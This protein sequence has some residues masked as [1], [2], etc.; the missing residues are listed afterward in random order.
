[1]S[2]TEPLAAQPLRITGMSVR[3]R[4]C[5]EPSALLADLDLDVGAGETAVILGDAGAGKTLLCLALIGGLPPERFTVAGMLGS[6][7]VDWDLAGLSLPGRR[8]DIAV[9]WLPTNP[10]DVLNPH[11]TVEAQF[12]ARLPRVATERQVRRLDRVYQLLEEVGLLAPEQT[13]ARAP[14]RLSDAE[15]QRVALALAFA[16]EPAFVIADDPFFS[17]SPSRRLPLVELL[18]R[19]GRR[20]R[21]T[22]LFTSR[23]AWVAA[24]F[25]SY[26]MV[27]CGGRAVERG[28]RDQVLER[29]TH[30]W[31]STF[32]GATPRH[33]RPDRVALPSVTGPPSTQPR[34]ACPYANHCALA[35]ED[36]TDRLPSWRS[37][38]EGHEVRCPHV[39]M[40]VPS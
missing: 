12:L 19:L 28:T 18:V 6:K 20:S 40:E 13:A 15:R 32:L 26:V 27:L 34:E 8:L 9:G 31:T 24:R 1:M 10:A 5:A 21:A 30:P 16:R 2:S 4:R 22:M 39:A 29:P 25:A 14:H 38:D 33:D 35:Q 36:C 37:L 17:L 7:G 23:E 3:D 11:A